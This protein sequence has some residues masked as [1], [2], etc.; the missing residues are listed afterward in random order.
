[1]SLLLDFLLIFRS[2]LYSVFVCVSF[3]FVFYIGLGDRSVCCDAAKSPSNRVIH[4][5]TVFDALT[6][7][8]RSKFDEV[9]H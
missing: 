1:M 6:N 5:E 8:S 4:C 9:V 2:V 7:V 3:F